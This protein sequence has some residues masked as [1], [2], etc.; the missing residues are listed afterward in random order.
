MK[1]K[2]TGLIFLSLMATLLLQKSPVQAA[3]EVN[4][5]RAIIY[6]AAEIGCYSATYISSRSISM[7]P[8]KKVYPVACTRY[9]HY[10]VFWSGKFKTRPGNPIPNGTESVNFCLKESNKLKYYGRNSS[11]YNHE[12]GENI[13]VG[14][15][16]PDKGPEAARFPKR[17]VCYIGLIT[18]ERSGTFKQVDQP[19]IRGSM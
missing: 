12:S 2:S 6:L 4:R 10:E 19:L 17:L 7:L 16:L 8:P 1:L 5:P 14:T 15:W 3:Q 13:G 18:T 11:S 9:H